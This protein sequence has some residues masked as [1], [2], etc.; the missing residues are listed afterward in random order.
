MSVGRLAAARRRWAAPASA[1]ELRWQRRAPGPRFSAERDDLAGRDVAQL[2]QCAGAAALGVRRQLHDAVG[3]GAGLDQLPG[4]ARHQ[5]VD[6]RAVVVDDGGEPVGIEDLGVHRLAP[7]CRKPDNLTR[8]TGDEFC[9]A[10]SAPD[11]R[12][13][14]GCD[15]TRVD[16]ALGLD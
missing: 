1:D 14:P 3:V 16:E 13:R 15:P 5:A 11:G 10:I 12:P 9:V 2:H 8:R 4:E 6:L 7:S